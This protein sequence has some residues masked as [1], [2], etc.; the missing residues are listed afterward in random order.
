MSDILYDQQRF[1]K[2]NLLGF[3]LAHRM[4]VG[5]FA[6]VLIERTGGGPGGAGY[7]S[8]TK[9]GLRLAVAEGR[10]SAMFLGRQLGP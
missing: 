4:F 8:D 7:V 3:C 2:E 9:K 5:A 10:R 1:V 6:A